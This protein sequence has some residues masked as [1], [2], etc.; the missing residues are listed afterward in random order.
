MRCPAGRGIGAAAFVLFAL[1][2]VAAVGVP[3]HADDT[4]Q[5]CTRE[6]LL[7]TGTAR[8][9]AS[10]Q[11]VDTGMAVAAPGSGVSLRTVG[12]SADGLAVDGSATALT[13]FVGAAPAVPGAT[14]P[15]GVV[16]LQYG[17]TV[18]VVVNGATVVLD[19][20]AMVA[21]EAPV[22]GATATSVL[23]RTG[24]TNGIAPLLAGAAL[25]CLVAGCGCAALA[26]RGAASTAGD[27]GLRWPPGVRPRAR[28]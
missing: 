13:V 11:S 7:W 24:P 8:L 18:D 20:C 3:V 25:V 27:R 28:G 22:P 19:R 4:G 1:S 26:R 15:G 6:T 16:R 23:P 2:G 5:D 12:V 17:G 9:G 14:V 10:L 21:S